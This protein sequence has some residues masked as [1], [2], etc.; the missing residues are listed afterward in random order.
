MRSSLSWLLASRRRVVFIT[1]AVLLALDL[2]R[3]LY[4]RVGYAEPVSTWQPNPAVYADIAW[5]P[6]SDLPANAPTGQRVFAQHCQVCHGPDGRGNG[7]AAPSLIP[8]PR[9]F[10]RG[11]FKY[12]TT[13]AGQPPSDADLMGVVSN[14]LQ[15]SAMPYWRDRLS[16]DELRAVVDYVKSLSPAFAGAAPQTIN[17][18]PETPNDAASVARGKA[19]FTA[20]GCVGCH[21]PDG[22]G[23]TVLADAKGYPVI[24]RDLTAPWT[25]R[26]GSAPE[27]IWMRITTGLAPGPMPSFAEKTTPDERWDLT[28]Y[29]QSLARVAPWDP[30]GTLGG[31]GQ[32]ADP[33][34]RGE[35]LVHA[36]MCGLCHTQINATGI[37][38]DDAYLAGGMRVEAYPH[39]VLVSRNLTSDPAT[40]LG[41][42]SVDEITN[43]IQNGRTRGRVLNVFDMPWI[44]LHNLSSDDAIAI[45]TYLKTKL[46][47]VHNE[48]PA[49]LRY[50][51]VETLINKLSRPLPAAPPTLLT[52]AVGNFGQNGGLPRDWPQRLLDIGQWLALVLGVIAFVFAAPPGRRLPKRPLGWVLAALAVLGLSACGLVGAAIY[53]LPQLELI[54]PEIIAGGGG[55]A[56]PR[57]L[58]ANLKTPEQAA[59]A[60]RG[61]Y[62]YSVASCALCHGDG[63]GGAKISWRP[64]GT[65]WS[66]NITP[67]PTT[68]IGQW[69]DAEIAR[70]IRSGVSRDGRALHWQGM[71]WDHASNWD[72]E[73][74]R[75][76]IVYLH[77]LPPVVKKIPDPTLPSAGDCAVY[78]IWISPSLTPGCKS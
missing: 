76:I 1:L 21:L 18:P 71:I 25:F 2:G 24:A 42:W 11:Q 58:P 43:A 30:G 23:G 29:V 32:Q 52:Y 27:Q 7:P 16:P 54:P 10:T 66:R 65:L 47:P 61:W 53:R 6:G 14:G 45:A 34:L 19:L 57:P 59:L 17:L 49:A 46:P 55:A 39:G 40:G 33:A 9:D 35:Y 5:P 31:P 75:A 36:E 69:S 63:S 20:Q 62:L 28:H 44:Q 74:L 68:G 73:D 41:N 37:Y 50:G 67:D 15:A 72:E 8:R 64:F 70:A 51:I 56:L 4:A 13:P 3:S 26:G 48:I 60:A 78:T 38:R 77:T 22:K 12:K